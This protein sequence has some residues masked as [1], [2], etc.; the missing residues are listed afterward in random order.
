MIAAKGDNNHTACASS[1]SPLLPTTVVM[2]PSIL[3]FFLSTSCAAKV[4][5]ARGTLNKDGVY[6]DQCSTVGDVFFQDNR[7]GVSF[8]IF[9][10]GP[11]IVY[12][13]I[14]EIYI[15]VDCELSKNAHLIHASFSSSQ[16]I[17]KSVNDGLWITGQT[18]EFNTRG[19]KGKR[20]LDQLYVVVVTA[21]RRQQTSETLGCCKMKSKS[22]K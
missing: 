20:S 7:D 3:V 8:S 11:E 12:G 9:L 14:Y 21:D 22:I 5:T 19:T 18:E 17:P 1:R 2:F 16:D 13:Q 6:C 15:G 10:K 4:Q